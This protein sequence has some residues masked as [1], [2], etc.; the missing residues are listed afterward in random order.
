MNY[1]TAFYFS[2]ILNIVI[3]T[4]MLWYRADRNDYRASLEIE[5]DYRLNRQPE[6]DEIGRAHV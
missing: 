1:E 5:Q 3:T 2:V 6:N 4:G